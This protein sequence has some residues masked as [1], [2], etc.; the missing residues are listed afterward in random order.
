MMAYHAGITS[1]FG[2]ELLVVWE[3]ACVTMFSKKQYEKIYISWALIK[4]QTKWL[5]KRYQ[6]FQGLLMIKSV[7]SLN[8]C[9]LLVCS[10]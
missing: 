9:F 8:L 5:E 10:S 2:R 3:C 6:T 7:L 4:Q 1:Y